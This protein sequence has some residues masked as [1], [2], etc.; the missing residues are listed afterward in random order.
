MMITL[1]VLVLLLLLSW[2]DD[3][4]QHFIWKILFTSHMLS[5]HCNSPS[6]GCVTK[7]TS[8]HSRYRS[9]IS[10]QTKMIARTKQ[11]GFL[12]ILTDHTKISFIH[13]SGL[14]KYKH[15]MNEQSHSSVHTI[16]KFRCLPSSVAVSLHFDSISWSIHHIALMKYYSK[17][18]DHHLITYN[19][20]LLLTT[21]F[22]FRSI[23]MKIMIVYLWIRSIEMSKRQC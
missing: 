22:W 10:T 23:E 18:H 20:S 14:W 19:S 15:T 2:Y 12:S 6:D 16:S 8:C 4:D 13:Q 11:D 5:K 21:D 9:T 17:Y 1:L 3:D 7:R